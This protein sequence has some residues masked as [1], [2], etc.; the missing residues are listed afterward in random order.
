MS[1]HNIG[2][3]MPV[4]EIFTS[5]IRGR[6]LY[7]LACQSW[8]MS[9]PRHRPRDDFGGRAQARVPGHRSEDWIWTRTNR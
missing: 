6:W 1:S 3:K 9:S 4:S 7:F 8:Q 5:A 2:S